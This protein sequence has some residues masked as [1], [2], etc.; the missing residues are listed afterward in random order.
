MRRW[1]WADVV[2]ICAHHFGARRSDELSESF[3]DKMKLLK[4]GV[5]VIITSRKLHHAKCVWEG[6]GE[7][8]IL[9]YGWGCELT[10]V[11]EMI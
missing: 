10:R 2:Y 6:T 4:P 7:L 11:Y 8:E 1:E 5:R 9:E 3:L